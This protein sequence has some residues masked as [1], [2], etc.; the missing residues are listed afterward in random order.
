MNI[1]CLEQTPSSSGAAV[2]QLTL[3]FDLHLEEALQKH[4]SPRRINDPLI[5]TLLTHGLLVRL[6][7]RMNYDHPVNPYTT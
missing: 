7:A 6:S 2:R 1:H 5:E 4:S 3:T